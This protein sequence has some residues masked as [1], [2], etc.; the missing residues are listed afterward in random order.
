[1]ARKDVSRLVKQAS[2]DTAV[3]HAC[4]AQTES[5]SRLMRLHSTPARQHC[6]VTTTSL[7]QPAAGPH[8]NS[9]KQPHSPDCARPL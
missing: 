7:Q 3:C 6:H 5:T 1:M 2:R 4:C 8:L 9:S